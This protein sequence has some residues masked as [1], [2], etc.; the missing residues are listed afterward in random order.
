MD[1]NL[2]RSAFYM[3]HQL[4]SLFRVSKFSRFFFLNDAKST[5]SVMR[6]VPLAI[7]CVS[8]VSAQELLP[9]CDSLGKICGKYGCDVDHC[10]LESKFG[11]KR[12]CCNPSFCDD[13]GKDVRG[14]V[15]NCD[16]K[17]CKVIPLDELYTIKRDG[18]YKFRQ[19]AMGN[20]LR[21]GK[22]YGETFASMVVLHPSV[23]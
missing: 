1:G 22:D 20:L 2:V 6:C 8:Y 19:Y 12:D 9:L 5:L 21:E 11:G 10:C 15:V 13:N 23:C 7:L 16:G 14:V 17:R 4:M 3:K 18:R